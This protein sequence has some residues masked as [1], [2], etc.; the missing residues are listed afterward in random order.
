MPVAEAVH[1][2]ELGEGG[3]LLLSDGRRA[4]LAAVDLV[5]RQALWSGAV[6][7]AVALAFADKGTDRHGD[8]I[9]HVFVDGH[10]LQGA[11]V[12]AGQARVRTRADMR[13]CARVL[14]AREAEARNAKR[15]LWIDPIHRI[16]KPDDLHGDIG[17]FQIVEGTVLAV[18]T[19]RGR[20]FLNFGLNRYDDF[21]VTIAPA[22]LK[23]MMKEG[24]NPA[25]WAGK[26]IRVRGWL[27]LL[28]GPELEV[29]HAEQVEL[30]D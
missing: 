18:S 1:V 11:L 2:R 6:Q 17:T 15:G 8:L 30:L 3:E 28:N 19:S 9:A 27:S 25:Q 4:R 20:A 10:W 29:T 7:R 16:R 24:S 12:T 13:R 22:A 21:T 5:D 26:T 23:R 14:L